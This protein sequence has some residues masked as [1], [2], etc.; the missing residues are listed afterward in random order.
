MIKPSK[1]MVMLLES[2]ELT[3]NYDLAPENKTALEK[4]IDENTGCEF[5]GVDL[6]RRESVLFNKILNNRPYEYNQSNIDFYKNFQVSVKHLHNILC[7]KKKM[8]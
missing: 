8:R 6:I 3:S 1:N 4:N 5:Y 7:D 2:P